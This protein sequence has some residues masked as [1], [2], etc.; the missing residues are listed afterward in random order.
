MTDRKKH[1]DSS[2][3]EKIKK[4]LSSEKAS[5]VEITLKDLCKHVDKN[6]TRD[7]N[8]LA[9]YFGK[10]PSSDSIVEIP[11]LDDFFE[12]FKTNLSTDIILSLIKI[13]LKS[14]SRDNY[15]I[16]ILSIQEI[17]NRK[18]VK[19]QKK[20]IQLFKQSC[21]YYDF[22]HRYREET[23]LDTLYD[24]LF[25]LFELDGL[26][27]LI[28]NGNMQMFD[29]Q[30]G[31][32]ADNLFIVAFE[33]CE[34]N[35]NLKKLASS[36]FLYK[37]EMI[38]SLGQA[39]FEDFQ[40]KITGVLENSQK[41]EFEKEMERKAKELRIFVLLESTEK[42]DIIELIE[43][44]GKKERSKF[45]YEDGGLIVDKILGRDDLSKGD[46][47]RALDGFIKQ[48]E[49]G[50]TIELSLG[51][52]A[53]YGQEK[54]F[55]YLQSKHTKDN[56][57]NLFFVVR[58]IIEKLKKEGASLD[59]LK[60]WFEFAQIFSAGDDSQLFSE[61]I[62]TM[63]SK[64]KDNIA[65]DESFHTT[66]E[67]LDKITSWIKN[68]PIEIYRLHLNAGLM[69]LAE[70]DEEKAWQAIKTVCHCLFKVM[71][72][73]QVFRGLHIALIASAK[74]S[75]LDSVK[76]FETFVPKDTDQTRL[77]YNL[78]CIYA[79]F[80]KKEKMINYVERSIK[81]GKPRDQFL[82]DNDF[83]P[84]WEDKDFLEVLGVG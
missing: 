23:V 84:Y 15:K 55:N 1:N 20:I 67:Q 33:K 21:S 18:E 69:S 75:D 24:S 72:A 19:A 50:C 34:K 83:K 74:T 54:F 49:N 3:L 2:V 8:P 60:P 48:K 32:G 79:M 63:F 68:S 40:N 35:A 43:E 22:G 61:E 42:E 57:E 11:I 14:I 28:N 58:G 44:I 62:A 53:N 56:E 59:E 46:L 71:V 10:I 12:K 4:E 51:F 38:S 13:S 29:P 30:D 66:I 52:I 37:K 80:S 73:Q 36:F 26:I 41:L 39:Y 78:A 25:P 70:R 9:E 76:A 82:E 81:L 5:S 47:L 45:I 27:S 6:C 31:D 16:A 65:Y 17:I 64:I 7:Y 77:T